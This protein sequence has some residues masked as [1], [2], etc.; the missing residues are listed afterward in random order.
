MKKVAVLLYPQFSN[1]ECSVAL[2]ILAQAEKPFD[3]FALSKA[4]VQSEEGLSVMPDLTLEELDSAAY[5]A[6]LLPGCMDAKW[7][8]DEDSYP[9]DVARYLRFVRQFD[10]MLQVIAAISS[11]P[12]LLAK[13]GLL[14]ERRFMI[15]MPPEAIEFLGFF[16]PEN[17]VEATG[18]NPCIC[19]DNVLTGVGSGFIQFGVQFGE[20][21]GLSFDPRWYG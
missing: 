18:A 11:A 16:K 9:E 12:A 13:A 19:E 10:P 7:F 6:L 20:M 4:P 1:Y 17:I 14:G 5:D 3:T 2:S 15:G 21:L 8:L